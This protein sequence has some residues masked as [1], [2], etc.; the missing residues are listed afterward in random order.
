MKG[1]GL[2]TLITGLTLALAASAAHAW[3]PPKAAA[4]K[5]AAKRTFAQNHPRRAEVLHRDNRQ[6]KQVNRAA[7]TGKLTNPQANRI[8]AQDQSIRRQEQQMSKLNGG[9]ITKGEQKVLNREE[10]H[11]H[12]EIKHDERKDAAKAAGT[13]AT[14][15]PAHSTT[16]PATTTPA[17]STTTPATT[18]AAQSNG[19]TFA[20][21]HPRRAEVVGRE[22]HQL[23]T[24]N[25]DVK[26]GTLTQQQANHITA[27]DKNIRHQE[28][29]MAKL[30]GGHITKG[31]QKV[32]NQEENKV[33]N[34]INRDVAKNAATSGT[35]P[36]G[37]TTAAP[38]T[39]TAPAGTATSTP[40]APAGTVQ[41][42]VSAKPAT[43]A[44]EHPRR[45]E[46]VGRENN[47]LG[48]TTQNVADGKLTA[49][50]GQKI[51]GQLTA[52]RQQERQDA[53]ANGGFI[54]KQQ[55]AQLNHEENHVKNEIRHDENKNTGSTT[56]AAQ[57][58]AAT[59]AFDREH[60]RR[61]EVIGRE[62]NLLGNTAQ[63]QTDGK[64]TGAQ[65]QQI[66]NQLLAIRQQER[67]DQAVNGG[68]ITKGQQNQLNREENH[69]RNEI[70]RD[71]RQDAA[72]TPT[73]VVPAN[74]VT[75]VV[76]ANPVPPLA[77]SQPAA[78]VVPTAPVP[79]TTG[80]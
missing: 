11:V 17:Q 20:E 37:G 78:P 22:Q 33:H 4:R 13:P 47:L 42:P 27:E 5:P 76:S 72:G 19:K 25:N 75:P 18:A 58:S 23:N 3:L 31:E 70:H 51:D 79:T 61:A 80:Q 54:T 46:V 67:H 38:A 74:P 48:S 15:T 35:A 53:A 32:L 41:A 71:E 40:A 26:S 49:A 30:N 66:D 39:P 44:Q 9:H 36:A 16:T 50:Q 68:F 6:V 64:L 24:V 43:F 63:A 7:A 1:S 28:Q 45:A 56:T 60:P 77:G 2:C 55:Q 73:P 12:H 10:N 29:E 65:S 59:A 57:Q 52:I 14:P 69:V 21:N 62:Q 34:Q 8:K